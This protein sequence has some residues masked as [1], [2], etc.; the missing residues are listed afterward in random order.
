[1]AMRPGLHPGREAA[2]WSGVTGFRPRVADGRL[3]W[4]IFSDHNSQA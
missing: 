3:F 1:M 4:S 2:A